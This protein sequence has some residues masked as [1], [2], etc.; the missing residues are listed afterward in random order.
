MADVQ[1]TAETNMMWATNLPG[2]DKERIMR[3]GG[4]GYASFGPN[5]NCDPNPQPH[6]IV[7]KCEI[8]GF[9][10]PFNMGY[11]LRA[12]ATLPQFGPGITMTPVFSFNH[13][14]TGHAVDGTMVGGRVNFAALAR[15]DLRQ[16][17]FIDT[18]VTWYRRGTKW[19]PA[20]DAG[21]YLINFGMRL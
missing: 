15:F 14:V 1:L 9:A 10:T 13:D 2:L 12:S 4:W 19:D 21:L 17:Y 6:G 11:R 16:R 20:R 7:N 8:D 3:W 18:G 5:G